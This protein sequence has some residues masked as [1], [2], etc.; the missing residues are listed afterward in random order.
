MRK[1]ALSGAYIST[2]S[3]PLTWPSSD[4]FSPV[5][6][7]SMRRP[8]RGLYHILQAQQC[9]EF[10]SLSKSN[11]FWIR[12]V[13]LPLLFI[14]GYGCMRVRDILSVG[15][16][17]ICQG[18]QLFKI[19]PTTLGFNL[20]AS[21]FPPRIHAVTPNSITKG[22][23]YPLFCLLCGVHVQGVELNSSWLWRHSASGPL[24]CRRCLALV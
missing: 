16:N 3:C 22:N 10:D 7:G 24:W 20:M 21:P 23:A 11:G 15:I 9:A 17:T 6:E 14:A 2:P 13:P 1:R 8:G 4:W 19:S 12:F 18:L 5:S